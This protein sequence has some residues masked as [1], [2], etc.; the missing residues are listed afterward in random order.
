MGDQNGMSLFGKRKFHDIPNYVEN[1]FNKTLHHDYDKTSSVISFLFSNIIGN[2][3][4]FL[5]PYGVRKVVYCDHIASSRALESIESYI[6]EHILPN[7]GNVHTTTTVTS[8]QSSMF[9]QEAR[10][11][12]TF[13]K[14][15]Y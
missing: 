7:Y 8:L 15:C 12:L 1:S 6:K 14:F 10:F 9:Q 4:C 13:H 3:Y 11:V 5:G 2:A